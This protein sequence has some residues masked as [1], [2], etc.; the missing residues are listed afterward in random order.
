MLAAGSLLAQYVGVGIPV[1][2]EI[3]QMEV[4]EGMTWE[5]ATASN[6]ERIETNIASDG[7]KT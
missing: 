3:K 6:A 7:D 2:A 5:R 4:S 1:R